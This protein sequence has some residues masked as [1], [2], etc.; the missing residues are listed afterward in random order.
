MKVGSLTAVTYTYNNANQP[1]AITQGTS[2]VGF[3][4]DAAGRPKTLTLPDG[5]V[6]TYGHDDASDLTSI[7]YTKGATTLGDLAYGYDAAGRRTALW[8]SYGRTGLPAATT[9]TASYNANNQ[10]TSWNGTTLSYDLNGNLTDFGS[11]SFT[12]N[13]RN[14][15]QATS[16][17]SASFAYDGLGRRL[18]KTIGGTTTKFLYDG[19]NGAQEQNSSNTATANLLTGL[20]IDQ[21]F[22]R[23]VVGGATSSLLTDALGS[24]IALA[25]ANGAVQTSYTY[26]P[27]GAVTSSGATNTNSYQ[28]TGRE[29]DGSTGLYFYRARYFSP[30]FGR[31]ISEDPLG[32]PGGPDPNLYGYVGSSPVL[33]TDPL[34]LDPGQESSSS[35]SETSRL[36]VDLTLF[37]AGYFLAGVFGGPFGIFVFGM[38]TVIDIE[39]NVQCATGHPL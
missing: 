1:T 4:Y 27:F 14:Q 20:G 3:T 5:I 7:A 29:N 36:I 18:S 34:G 19:A 12:W 23:Q 17:G 21:T 26:E 31:F 39:I 33:F 11:Q 30:T 25:D 38:T 16:A 6:Q 28:F 9:A 35:C 10:L 22:S 8:G 24:T 15:L 37:S 13:D 32:F 2:S